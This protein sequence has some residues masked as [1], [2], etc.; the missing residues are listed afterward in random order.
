VK[1]FLPGAQDPHPVAPRPG[2]LLGVVEELLPR[3]RRLRGIET[4]L[5]EV[6]GVVHQDQRVQIVRQAVDL[7]LVLADLQGLLV[8]LGEVLVAA[9]LLD[10]GCQV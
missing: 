4:R 3:R 6:L 1:P 5:S 8:P 9:L 10:E 2:Q 7:P